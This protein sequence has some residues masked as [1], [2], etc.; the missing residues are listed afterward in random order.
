[1]P[2]VP[3]TLK[4]NGKVEP[5]SGVISYKY[6]K[7]KKQDVITYEAPFFDASNATTRMKQVKAIIQRDDKGN[8]VEIRNDQNLSSADLK[9]IHTQYQ[10]VV[11]QRGQTLNS[12]PFATLSHGIVKFE[13][14]NNQC[15]PVE[16]QNVYLTEPKVGGETTYTTNF[17]LNL[18]K[19]IQDFF[20]KNPEAESCF[21]NDLNQKMSSLFSQYQS[22]RVLSG[23]QGG[24]FPGPPSLES[25]LY[26]D[27]GG[28]GPKR[29]AHRKGLGMSPIISGHMILQQCLEQQLEP[30]LADDTIWQKTTKAPAQTEGSGVIKN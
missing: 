12:P 1:M 22:T 29:K 10:K 3:F 18:C 14:K 2:N 8:I 23:V 27:V 25:L 28:F 11:S 6:D 21:K 26:R 20:Q 19:D 13:I 15:T 24:G 7:A 16:S 4:E 5:L 30:F 9:K 17:Y